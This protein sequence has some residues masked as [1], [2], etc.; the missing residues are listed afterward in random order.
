MADVGSLSY[1]FQQA[2]YLASKIDATLEEPYGRTDRQA[3]AELR[4]LLLAIIELLDPLRENADPAPDVMTIPVGLVRRL[5]S[6]HFDGQPMSDALTRLASEIS[7]LARPLTDAD[8]RLLREISGETEREASTA[9]R[10]M[11][12]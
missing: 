5:R 10:R 4:P 7:D 12:R 8:L 9:F 3:R 11:V 1:E 2:S 6:K